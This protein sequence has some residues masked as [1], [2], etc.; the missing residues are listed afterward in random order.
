[1]SAWQHR[2]QFDPER[3][4]LSAWLVAITAHRATTVRR[5]VVRRLTAPSPNDAND[6]ETRLDLADAMRSLTPRERLAIDC[7]YFAGL[8]VSE[9]ARVMGCSDGTVKSTLATARDRLRAQVR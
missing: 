2:D 5:K 3:G 1:L 4:S 6:I 8:S 9:S 7:Y